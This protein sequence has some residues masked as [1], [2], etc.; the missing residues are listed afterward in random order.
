M[1]RISKA[2]DLPACVPQE[3]AEKAFYEARAVRVEEPDAHF[4][5][6]RVLFDKGNDRPYYTLL[7]LSSPEGAEAL[8]ELSTMGLNCDARASYAFTIKTGEI[9]AS[10]EWEHSDEKQG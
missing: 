10:A 6:V 9:I 2:G 8:V 1:L 3:L 5:F 4:A 7:T